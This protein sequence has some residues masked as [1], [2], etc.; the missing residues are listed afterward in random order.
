MANSMELAQHL[1]NDMLLMAQSCSKARLPVALSWPSPSLKSPCR[2]HGIA[3]SPLKIGIANGN[4][5]PLDRPKTEPLK[6]HRGSKAVLPI[7]SSWPSYPQTGATKGMLVASW[8][9]RIIPKQCYRWHMVGRLED[10]VG[11]VLMGQSHREGVGFWL[12]FSWASLKLAATYNHVTCKSIVI[13]SRNCVNGI[14]LALHFLRRLL[15]VPNIL[16]W[17]NSMLSVAPLWSDH[18]PSAACRSAGAGPIPCHWPCLLQGKLS[19]SN[20]ISMASLERGWAN[21]KPTVAL[22]WS[23]SGPSAACHLAG[24]GPIPH[25]WPCLFQGKLGQSHAIGIVS[26]EGDWANSMP[27]VV[28]LRSDHGPSAVCHLA[29]AG[30]I[31]CYR[32]GL[33]VEGLGQLKATGSLTLEQ[34]WAISNM[35]FSRC[36]ANSTLLA[37]PVSREAGSIPCYRHGLFGEGLGQLKTTSSLALEQLWATSMLLA[38]PVSREAGTIPCYQHC[39]FRGRLGQLDAI[40]SMPFGRCWGN[41]MLLAWSL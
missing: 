25:Y 17:A 34:L 20:V 36:W 28:L 12:L 9:P 22:P 39:I 32:H 18:G 40:G 24:V 8:L 41:P 10:V 7:A 6:A 15:M 29:G 19:Q 30:P 35:S 23:N 31:P 16:D 38:M 1:P 2:Q 37:I 11:N 33:F 14:E 26:L 27:L 21:S 5:W 13:S 4:E 3:P